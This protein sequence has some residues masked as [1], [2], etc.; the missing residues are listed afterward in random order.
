M[1]TTEPVTLANTALPA[2]ILGGI[3]YGLPHLLTPAG[4]RSHTRLIVALVKSAALTLLAAMAIFALL[5]DGAVP[6]LL[7]APGRTLLTLAGPAA[8]SAIIWLPLLLLSGYNR[9]TRIEDL[10]GRDITTEGRQTP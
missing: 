6:A 7:A 1:L 9:A 10:K 4:T 8:L 2:V 3:G 5:Y